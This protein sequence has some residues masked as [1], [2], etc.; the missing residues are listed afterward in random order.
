MSIASRLKIESRGMFAT[1]IFYAVVGIIFLTLLPLTGFP[2]HIAIMGIFSLVTAYGIFQKRKWALWLV[3][4][5]FFV[6][7]A[8]SLYMMYYYIT[9]DYIVGLSTTAYLI[10]TWIFTIYA[11]SKRGTLET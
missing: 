8:F 9:R 3:V 7:S 10:L 4:I 11:A 6:A 2:P 1:S 5:M